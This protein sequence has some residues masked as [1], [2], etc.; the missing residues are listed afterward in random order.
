MQGK[1][2]RIVEWIPTSQS[3]LHMDL[4]IWAPAIV[5]STRVRVYVSRD[6][7]AMRTIFCWLA[8]ALASEVTPVQKVALLPFLLDETI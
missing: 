4:H 8:L 3:E 7:L 1:S 6:P 2:A 5:R